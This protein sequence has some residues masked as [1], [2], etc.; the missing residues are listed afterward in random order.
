VSAGSSEMAAW[1]DPGANRLRAVRWAGVA[2][3]AALGLGT[4]MPWFVANDQ[5]LNVVVAEP[6]IGP[7][8]QGL[9][10]LVLSVVCALAFAV[11]TVTAC[12]VAA[13]LG[14]VAIVLSVSGLQPSPELVAA[15]GLPGVVMVGYGIWVSIAAGVAAAAVGFV[16]SFLLERS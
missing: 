13:A 1:A 14:V 6:G 15:M 12:R 9:T 2:A 11:T 4:L 5:S 8:G 7:G 10:V 16:G 3:A